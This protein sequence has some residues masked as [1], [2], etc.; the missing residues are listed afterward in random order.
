VQSIENSG[1]RNRGMY[2][3]KSRGMPHS[4]QIREFLIT[5]HGVD[6]VDVYIGPSGVLTGSAR[7]Q[8]EARERAEILVRSQELQKQRRQIE[9]KRRMLESQIAALRAE[10]DQASAE[11]ELTIDQSEAREQR[12]R[13]DRTEMAARRGE[14]AKKKTNGPATARARERQSS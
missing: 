8:Q 12:L 1:E 3:L 10:F 2:V 9:A 5:S 4:N 6:L 11:L 13:E 7:V 14:E